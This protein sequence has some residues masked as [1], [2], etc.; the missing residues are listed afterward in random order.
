MGNTNFGVKH[1]YIDQKSYLELSGNFSF[2]TDIVQK[3]SS[4]AAQNVSND[5]I[6][7][8]FAGNIVNITNST[9][10]GGVNISGT[11]TVKLSC[12]KYTDVF[13]MCISQITSIKEGTIAAL[14]QQIAEK[15]FYL[16]AKE[17]ITQAANLG[18]NTNFGI[19]TDTIK[20]SDETYK[21]FELLFKENLTAE[22]DNKNLTNVVNKDIQTAFA[23]NIVNVSNSTIFDGITVIAP[24]DITQNSNT[25]NKITY[26]LSQAMSNALGMTIDFVDSSSNSIDFTQIQDTNA[27]QETGSFL[28]TIAYGAVELASN[29]SIG[30]ILAIVGVIVV[31]VAFFVA[32][33]FIIRT[34]GVSESAAKLIDSKLREEKLSNDDI[35]YIDNIIKNSFN[36]ITQDDTLNVLRLL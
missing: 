3:A 21:K 1:K 12:I 33:V 13:S 7:T 14:F 32:A 6:Q 22:L 35:H 11:N 30:F 8:G 36:V 19:T 26:I 24:S 23:G 20:F 10:F 17:N 25:V 29:A 16:D 2:I 4:Q 28:D 27:N 18:G 5:C 34:P 9:I 15:Q 31:I